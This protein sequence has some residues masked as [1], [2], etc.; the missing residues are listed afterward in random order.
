LR[1]GRG[2]VK[3]RTT[4]RERR[5]N[6]NMQVELKRPDLAKFVDDKV[7]SGDFP[8][9]EAVVEDALARMMDEEVTLSDDDVSAINAAEE[10]IDR[11]ESIDFD[12]FATRMRKRYAAE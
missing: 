6:L 5:Y 10:Q 9:R 3:T 1:W 8:S 4:E 11:G 2:S 7:K 12:E